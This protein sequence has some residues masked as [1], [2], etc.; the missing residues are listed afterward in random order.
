MSVRE[1]LE[2]LDRLQQQHEKLGIA[3]ATVKK[4]SDDGS[5]NL[6]SMIAFW[7]I[8]SIFPLFLVLV[9]ILG[10]VLSN[11]LR[12]DVLEHVSS[13]FPLLDPTTVEGLTGS[14]W[15]IL[16]GGITA[17]WS[18][19]AVV[20]TTQVAFDSVWGIPPKDRPGFLERTARSLWVLGTVGVGLVAATIVSGY[21]TGRSTA[22]DLGWFGRLA[23][24]LVTLALDVGLFVAAFRMLTDRK[25]TWRD[26]LPGALLSGGMFWILQ[27][28][29][30][31]I[32]S[33]YLNSA[34]STY[35]NFAT[36][37]TVL[38]WFYLQAQITLL[39]AQLNVV[40]K[41]G[42]HPRSLIGEPGREPHAGSTGTQP[43]QAIPY[44][45]SEVEGRCEG[46]RVEG[47]GGPARGRSP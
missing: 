41:K 47:P 1:R 6:A 42:L 5:T 34:Q 13:Y 31:L 26:V 23:G 37:I 19:S 12:T 4:F 22:L 46:E 21:V 2:R 10:Y 38:W 8:F 43:A 3:A 45:R 29:S 33:R 25:I 18:G 9:T 16:V 27:Q 44:E 32:I 17:F 7:A 14:W 11:E 30:S 36:V 15:P 35:G 28:I 20:R 24:H 40:L 39:G